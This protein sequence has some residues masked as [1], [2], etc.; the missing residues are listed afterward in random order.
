MLQQVLLDTQIEL[1]CHFSA[2]VA[3]RAVN[4]LQVGID[5]LLTDLT[6]LV[7]IAHTLDMGIRAE[8]KVDLVGIVDGFLCKLLADKLREITADLAG[9]GQLSVGESAC[10]GESGGDVAIGLA[11]HADLCLCL[12]TGSLLD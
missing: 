4:Q 3:Y 11:I 5:R 8:L 6:D 12:R 2:Q 9:Q 1:V 7:R 10:A